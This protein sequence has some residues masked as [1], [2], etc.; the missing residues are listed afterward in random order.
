M[1][2]LEVDRAVGSAGW[3]SIGNHIIKVAELRAGTRVGI[4]L[5]DTTLTIFDPDTRELLRVAPNPITPAELMKV[6]GAR[7]A[8]P[9]P[10]PRT[11]P[12]RVQRLASN[13]GGISV[14]RQKIALGRVHAR[15]IVT[16]H[17]S[18]DMLTIELDDGN[19]TVRRTTTDPVQQIK[20]HRP[21][22]VTQI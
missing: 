9:P 20:A 11:A 10:Q 4:R 15:Q 22:K 19:R 1:P 2:A 7:P 17:V 16:M 14:C 5:D 12:V 6:R 8:G 3:V 13:S 18:H 21:R